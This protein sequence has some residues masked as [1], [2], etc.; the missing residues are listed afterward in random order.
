MREGPVA[1]DRLC[2]FRKNPLLDLGRKW[3][4]LV[5]DRPRLNIR[6]ERASKLK[7]NLKDMNE[8]K[9][10]I[11]KFKLEEDEKRKLKES[12]IIKNKEQEIEE[13]IKEGKKLTTEDFLMFQEAVKNK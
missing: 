5:A 9:E 13:K 3:K 2:L 6:N 12:T 1:H 11:N 10:K 4:V 8:I 7:E